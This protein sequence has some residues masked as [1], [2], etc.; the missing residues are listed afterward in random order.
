MPKNISG[1]LVRAYV[2][3]GQYIYG[4]VAADGGGHNVL[5]RVIKGKMWIPRQD[6]E[7]HEPKRAAKGV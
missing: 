4:V 5:V 7:I 1:K 3:A 6:V 2:G